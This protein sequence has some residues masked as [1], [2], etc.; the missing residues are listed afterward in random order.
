MGGEFN[1]EMSMETYQKLLANRVLLEKLIAIGF[2]D[3]K[4]GSVE[5]H[6]DSSGGIGKIVSHQR[7]IG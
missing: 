7:L 5:V 4:S 6:F 2:F 1:D 3:I